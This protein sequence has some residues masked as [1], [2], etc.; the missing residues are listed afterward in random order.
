MKRALAIAGL[1]MI[2]ANTFAV[3]KAQTHQMLYNLIKVAKYSNTKPKVK[4]DCFTFGEKRCADN[5]FTYS[6]QY[7]SI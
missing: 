1:V 6:L 5:I 7:L 4:Q 3:S 2:F